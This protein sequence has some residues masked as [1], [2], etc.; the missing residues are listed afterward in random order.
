MMFE[1]YVRRM[2]RRPKSD[3]VR[4]TTGFTAMVIVTIGLLSPVT[5]GPLG[6]LAA[7]AAPAT[8]VAAPTSMRDCINTGLSGCT[9]RATLATNTQVTMYC[10]IDGSWATGR[11]SSNRW[12]FV[13]G[14]GRTGFV[15]SSM[16][17]NQTSVLPC[18]PR[19][20]GVM[21][22][23]WA[24][25]HVNIATTTTLERST[26]GYQ[27]AYWSGYCAGFT[28]SAYR[29]GAG[30]QPRFLGDARDRFYSYRGAGLV[31]TGSPSLGAMVFWPNLS[32]WG[33]TAIYVGN[34]MVATTMGL[35]GE[36]RANALVPL[37]Y[38][39]APAG[40]VNSSNV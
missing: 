11:Y 39:G 20:R 3:G 12:F 38:F 17:V 15:H 35:P 27:T 9:P 31:Q 22:T 40:W 2:V 36:R 1:R 13:A 4:W 25:E 21:A 33:H 32:R 28:S 26:I 7:E 5:T 8:R 23:K 18:A 29:L 10:W 16:V 34:G 14:G 24:A 30:V 19:Y 6:P 37:N